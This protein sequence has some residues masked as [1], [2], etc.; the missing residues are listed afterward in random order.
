MSHVKVNLS[1]GTGHLLSMHTSR[2]N[3]ASLACTFFG[4]YIIVTTGNR[5]HKSW[6]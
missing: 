5:K 6:V 2:L 4:I 1:L 3:I